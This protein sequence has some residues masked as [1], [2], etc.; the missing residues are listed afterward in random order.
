MSGADGVH[1]G[2]SDLPPQH[3]RAFLGA[4][5]LIGLSTHSLNQARSGLQEPIDYLALGPVFPT[6]TKQDPDPVVP[7]E[8]QLE[9]LEMAALP[10]VA[11]GG[12]T[13]ERAGGLWER[14][15]QSVA[16]ISALEEE[17]QAGW[18]EFMRSYPDMNKTGGDHGD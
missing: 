12:I 3:A 8:L 16:V 17:P 2:Q 1:L 18:R 6:S 13:A 10:T 9:V 7:V 11:I 4:R 14:G 5:S 15:F